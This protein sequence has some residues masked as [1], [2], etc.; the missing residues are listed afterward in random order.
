VTSNRSSS[1]AASRIR[2]PFRLD[3]IS[4]V[5]HPLGLPVA[6]LF[7][8]VLEGLHRL[9]LQQIEE[10]LVL[11]V[12]ETANRL[13]RGCIVGRAFRESDPAGF[14]EAA[15]PVVA[16]LAVHVA[17]VVLLDLER[18]PVLAGVVRTLA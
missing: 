13:H 18:R 8:G 3:V 7:D 4:A 2:R 15:D 9:A 17:E 12:A 16:G 10:D 5:P 14:Q 1:P 6:D 11:T